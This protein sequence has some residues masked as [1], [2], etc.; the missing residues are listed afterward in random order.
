MIEI[1]PKLL[2]DPELF[3]GIR[4]RI[5]LICDINFI[6]VIVIGTCGAV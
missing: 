6:R 4:Q 3:K 1:V 5:M 2:K